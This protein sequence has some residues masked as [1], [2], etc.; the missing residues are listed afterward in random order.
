MRAI[1]AVVPVLAAILFATPILAFA[2]TGTVWLTGTIEGQGE[3][4]RFKIPLEWLAAVDNAE[5]DTIRVEDVV[6]NAAELWDTHKALPVGESKQV[7]KGVSKDGMAYEVVV[8]SEALSPQ[9]AAG[10]VR[11]L[12]KDKNGKVT[13]IGFPLDIPGLIQTVANALFR[14]EGGQSKITAHS[15]SMNN[16]A[17]LRRLADY[18][19]FTFFEGGELDS[20]HVKIWIE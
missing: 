11:I 15:V 12:N 8:V 7:R 19:P 10:K 3:G 9:K 1:R 2:D 16:P 6:V 14:V 13:D 17:D 5:A 4:G 20:S 18:G